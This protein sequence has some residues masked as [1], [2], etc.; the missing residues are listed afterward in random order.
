MAMHIYICP[1]CDPSTKTHLVDVIYEQM[2]CG[3]HKKEKQCKANEYKCKKAFQC[4]KC[5]SYFKRTKEFLK[6]QKRKIKD[7]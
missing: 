5:K 2:K 6:S 7:G 4:K 1:H 3:E